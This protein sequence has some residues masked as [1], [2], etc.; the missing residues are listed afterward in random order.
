MK[1]GRQFRKQ[2]WKLKEWES[3]SY[4]ECKISGLVEKLNIKCERGETGII[5]DKAA[6]ILGKLTQ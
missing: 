2:Q 6:F 1:G 4:Y 5:D 3:E